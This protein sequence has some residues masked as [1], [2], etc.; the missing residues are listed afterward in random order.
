MGPLEGSRE[1]PLLGLEIRLI[2]GTWLGP[3]EGAREGTMLG[4]E[5]GIRC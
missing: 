3:L 5:L 4:L 1:V 2:L